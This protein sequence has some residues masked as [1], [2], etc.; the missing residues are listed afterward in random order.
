MS[1]IQFIIEGLAMARKAIGAN[2]MRS[3]LTMLGVATG[4]FAITGILTMVNSLQTS[5]TEN[6]ASLGNT[7]LFVHHWPWAE[8]GEEWYKF[9]N[10]PQ[11][12]YRDY[13]KLKQGLS[14]VSGVS[15]QVS[16]RNQTVRAEG[17]SVSLVEVVGVTHDAVVVADMRFQRGRYFSEVESHLGSAV[18]IVGDNV[19]RQLFPGQD[20]LGQYVRIQ[21]RRLRIIG[22]AEKKGSSLFPGMVS[23]DDRVML[24]YKVLANMFNVNMRGL[25]KVIVIKAASHEDLPY[26]ED[27]I[28]GLV[29]A[30]RGLKPR[31][32][33]N[34][35][36]NKQEALMNTF[37][38]FFGNLEIGGWVISI[39]SILIGGFSIGNIMYI[40]VRERTN[41]IGVQKA[42]GSTRSFI[43]YQFLSESVLICLIGGLIG[44]L[45]AFMLGALVQ[46]IMAG[47]DVPFQVR[48][49][50][51]DV[52]LAM[53]L[54]VFIG[55]VSGFV[56]AVLASRLDPVSAI[57]HA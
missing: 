25:D 44:L 56:P 11:V 12:D 41:E 17:R 45:L 19:A 13:W 39:F 24:P 34:F 26:V 8:R 9:I 43:L 5:L 29:R 54:S 27:E 46:A 3:F 14:R 30:A 16:A 20:A 42:L 7:T 36:I 1:I 49:A 15:Y 40:S 4:I 53:G 57:R 52:L 32:E 50:A 18:C 48:F 47:M 38:R 21:G 35:A 33:N 31:T 28:T 22:V 2:R 51:G 6:I 37:D 55:L 23:D 10:R